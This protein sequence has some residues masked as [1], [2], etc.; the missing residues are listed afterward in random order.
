VVPG[1]TPE[2]PLTELQTLIRPTFFYIPLFLRY[3]KLSKQ[4][5]I[6]LLY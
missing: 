6:Q 5:S 4:Y 1:E 3:G 2:Q